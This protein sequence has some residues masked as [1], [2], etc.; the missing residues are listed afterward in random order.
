MRLASCPSC[1]GHNVNN[2]KKRGKWRTK[3]YDCGYEVES[4]SESRKLARYSWN[5][6]YEWL[7]KESLP[8]EMCG[9]QKGAYTKK[10]IKA[11]LVVKEVV[12]D[13]G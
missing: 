10:E 2:F 5:L 1:K 9:R 6:N 7:T 8:D 13:S 11:G 4:D 3:C 12:E